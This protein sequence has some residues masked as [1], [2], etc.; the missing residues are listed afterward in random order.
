MNPRDSPNFITSES[1]SAPG[2]KMK[3]IGD[4]SLD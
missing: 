1:G 3:T 2:D 4:F